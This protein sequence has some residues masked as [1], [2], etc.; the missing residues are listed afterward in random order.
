M[1]ISKRPPLYSSAKIAPSLCKLV[2]LKELLVKIAV[3]QR[4][5]EI[6]S[7]AGSVRNV[8]KRPGDVKAGRSQLVE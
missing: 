1:R 5:R 3:F 2:S 4:I 7:D 6:Q 8:C